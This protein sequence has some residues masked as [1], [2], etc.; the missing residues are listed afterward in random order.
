VLCP[1][2]GAISPDI[3]PLFAAGVES[4]SVLAT[5]KAKHPEAH[6]SVGARHEAVGGV[7]D[8]TTAE[9][10]ERQR[11]GDDAA[12]RRGARRE[13]RH[14]MTTCDARHTGAPAA[15]LVARW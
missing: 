8:L 3:G 14:M 4:G 9:Y 10:V 5:E 7:I 6:R 11:T 2:G 15:H 1:S 12:R 13:T